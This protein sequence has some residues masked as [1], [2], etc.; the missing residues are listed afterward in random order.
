MAA[1]GLTKSTRVNKPV[2]MLLT[3]LG[4]IIGLAPVAFFLGRPCLLLYVAG[5]SLL[6]A[7]LVGFSELKA[8]ET[9]ATNSPS[10][11][12]FLLGGLSVVYLPAAGGAGLLIVYGLVYGGALLLGALLGWLGLHARIV[13]EAVAYYPTAVFAVLMAVGTVEGV[14][15]LQSKLYPDVAGIESAFYD[16]ISR[17]R[18]ILVA[19]SAPAV[20]VLGA[21]L[22]AF[23]ANRLTASWFCVF[24][25]VY[26]C[27]VTMPLGLAGELPKRSTSAIDAVRK[28]LEAS[29]YQTTMSPRTEDRD[30][31]IDPLLMNVDLFAYN[32]ERALAL[33]VKTRGQAQGLV[34]WNAA[35]ALQDAAWAL[36]ELS[37]KL[38]LPSQ[39]VEPLMVLIGAE[40]DDSLRAFSQAESVQI[41][42]IPEADVPRIA[43]TVDEDDL[44]EMAGRYPGLGVSVGDAIAPDSEVDAPGG[45]P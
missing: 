32:E 7:V 5:A 42:E 13:P 6:S 33:Q 9:S 12:E 1:D 19:C 10:F 22:A 43:V 17:R 30:E 36:D 27:I 24:L 28:L 38:G 23:L 8:T 16:L 15:E 20:L 44:R 25:Q 2:L 18:G 29:G 45:Q 41:V 39:Q 37:D 3:W 14:K 34:D 26:L 31:A 40:P 35:S 21:V 4:S 11:L